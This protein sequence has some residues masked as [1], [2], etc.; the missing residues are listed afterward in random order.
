MTGTALEVLRSLPCAGDLAKARNMPMVISGV[1]QSLEPMFKAGYDFAGALR[2]GGSEKFV[3]A[4]RLVAYPLPPQLRDYAAMLNEMAATPANPETILDTVTVVTE[5]CVGRGPSNWRGYLLSIVGALHS[6]GFGAPIVANAGIELL[7]ADPAKLYSQLPSAFH[8]IEKCERTKACLS[9]HA[10]S[11][12]R[13]VRTHDKASDILARR[14][15]I[16]AAEK[17]ESERF[18]AYMAKNQAERIAAS[19]RRVQAHLAEILSLHRPG[20]K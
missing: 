15:E 4:E 16:E 10:D 14:P 7:E 20:S 8:W 19:E 6:R 13:L 12:G 3:M 17:A 2:A 18:K 1:R 11:F 5:A 9:A